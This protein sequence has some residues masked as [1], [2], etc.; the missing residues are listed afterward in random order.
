MYL[1]F[2]K[3]GSENTNESEE[4]TDDIDDEL[5]D[6]IEE[7]RAHQL[8]VQKNRLADQADNFIRQDGQDN[9]SRHPGVGNNAP[10]ADGGELSS[11]QHIHQNFKDP[12]RYLGYSN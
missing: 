3:R 5:N 11:Q 1:P 4:E 7:Y 8:S 2:Y 12:Y 9:V 10:Y 6:N